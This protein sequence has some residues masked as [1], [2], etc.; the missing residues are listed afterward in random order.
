MRLRFL[1]AAQE[2]TGSL[3]LVEVA[4][5]TIVVD[6]GMFQGRRE[7]SRQ[8]NRELPAEAIGADVA[9]LTHSHIDHSGNLPTLVKSGFTGSIYA[10]PATFDLCSYMLRDSARIQTGDAAYLNRK[11]ESDPDW[12]PLVPLYD[13]EDVLRALER[14]VAMPYH[15]A[16]EPLPGVKATFL[17]SG[18][19]LG[20]AQVV[21]DISENGHSR[22]LLVSGDLG[23]KG[24]PIIRDPEQPPL[25]VDY[26]VIESTYGNR[27]H[28][29]VEQMHDD[30]E[31]V[32]K[33]TVRRG[34]KLI[35]PAFAVGR[36]QEILYVLH[37][38]FKAG[39]LPAIPIFIDSPLAINVTEVFRLHPECFD[40]ETRSFLD[41]HGDV[42]SFKGVRYVRTPEESLEINRHA[43]PAIIIS[44]SGMAEAGRVL[45]HLRNHVG[46]ERSTILIVGYMAQHTLGRRF[47]E[48]RPRVKIWGIER[49]VRARVEVL[50]AFS[51]HADRGDLLKYIEACGTIRRV[52]LVHGEPDQQRPLRATLAERGVCV[53]VPERGDSIELD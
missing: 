38:L 39:R 28:G 11:F 31:R 6:C 43:G 41:E 9:I 35:V 45:H 8:R 48:R 29:T 23:R 27:L 3:L 1:G 42:F 30:L 4:S 7:E 12:V 16:F 25:P 18:H 36:T 47:V 32:V 15:H 46:D 44:A 21:L 53:A 24:L 33:D 13:E 20:S 17:N 19:I 5:G 51:A 40:A 14:F 22:R 34:G 49:D 2:V 52:F 26:L 37:G 10:T 50:N